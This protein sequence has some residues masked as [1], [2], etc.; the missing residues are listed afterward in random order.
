MVGKDGS[1]QE[2]MVLEK[3]LRVDLDL[4]AG[5]RRLSSADRLSSTLGRD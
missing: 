3:E 1:V 4:W 5:R 2:N